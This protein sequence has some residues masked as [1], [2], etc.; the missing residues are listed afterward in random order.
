MHD[1]IQDCNNYNNNDMNLSA[2]FYIIQLNL[3]V[4]SVCRLQPSKPFLSS[5]TLFNKCKIQ[6][7]FFEKYLV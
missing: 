2:Q 4:K 6:N 5:Q 1:M 7:D 3:L